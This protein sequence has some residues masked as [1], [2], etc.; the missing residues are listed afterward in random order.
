MEYITYWF[1]C[2]QLLM[3]TS[4][5]NDKSVVVPA[6]SAPSAVWILRRLARHGINTIAVSEDSTTPAFWSRYCD[7]RVLIPSPYQDLSGYREGLIS[8]AQREDVRA[9]T[10]VREAD[11]FTLAKY[12]SEFNEHVAPLWPSINLL[13][14]VHDRQRLYAAAER[15]NVPY[16]ETTNLSE[17]DQWNGEYIIKA[18]WAILV[19]DYLDTVPNGKISSPPKTMFID[20]GTVP[21]AERIQ[22]EMAHDPIVQEFVPGTEYCFRALYDNGELVVSTQ[23]RLIRGYKYPRGPSI[24][25]EAVDIPELRERGLDLLDELDWH[26]LASVGF[27]RDQSGTFKLLEVNPRFW[28]SLPVDI[29]AGVDYPDIY[30]NTATDDSLPVQNTYRPGHGSHHIMGEIAHAHSVLFESYP[31]ATKPSILGTL[32]GIPVSMAVNRRFDYLSLDD[33]GPFIKA[34]YNTARGVIGQSE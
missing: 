23:K 16:P 20:R 13:E 4:R 32:I 2:A 25:H 12:R 22:D 18:R 30:W 7:E 8:L 31:L 19:G 11:V 21:D 24:Y 10:P 9:I 29:F 5:G 28:A 26:G 34:F 1:L 15:A 3:G 14:S 6:V 27:I 33:P 17:T